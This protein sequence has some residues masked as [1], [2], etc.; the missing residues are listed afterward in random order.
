MIVIYDSRV[1]LTRNCP[2]YD[3]RVVIYT[4]KMFYS[5]DHRL[6]VLGARFSSKSKYLLTLGFLKHYFYVKTTLATFGGNFK[7]I[8]GYF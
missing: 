3:S 7:E 8:L 6:K 5:I 2:Y 4:C 1:V